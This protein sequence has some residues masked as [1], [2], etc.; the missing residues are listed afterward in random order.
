MS[1]W[2]MVIDDFK[3]N[4]AILTALIMI[5]QQADQLPA[6]TTDSSPENAENA[7]RAESAQSTESA[8]SAENTENTENAGNPE[9]AENAVLSL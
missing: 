4:K 9:K 8:E 5:S 6:W 2:A 1:V 7:E 3:R